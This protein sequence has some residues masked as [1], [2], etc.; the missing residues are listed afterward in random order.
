MLTNMSCDAGPVKLA[1][2]LF[3]GLASPEESHFNTATGNSVSAG[4]I[5]SVDL[6]LKLGT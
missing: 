3:G 2:F 4:S 5:S 1:L 6:P